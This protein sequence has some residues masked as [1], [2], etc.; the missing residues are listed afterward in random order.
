MTKRTVKVGLCGLGTVGQ[1]VLALLVEGNAAISVRSAAHLVVTHI[2]TR[3]PRP[4]VD[5]GAVAH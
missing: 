4:E 1:G 5:I 3:T 2:G